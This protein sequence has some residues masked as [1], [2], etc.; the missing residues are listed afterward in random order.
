MIRQPQVRKHRSF[1]SLV[2][3]H[4][5][6]DVVERSHCFNHIRSLIQHYTLSRSLIAAPVISA[7]DGTPSLV[8]FSSTYVAQMTGIC[9]ASHIIVST[10]DAHAVHATLQKIPHPLIILCCF[11]WHGHHDADGAVRWLW[12]KQF[13]SML[14]KQLRSFPVP[15]RL[16]FKLY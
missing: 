12:S 5:R 14:F 8:S 2:S 1:L 7:R 3:F 11:G 13:F 6:Q 4:P 10:V 16:M 9:A 15:T